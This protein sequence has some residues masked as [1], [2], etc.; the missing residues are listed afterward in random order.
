MIL[1]T[2]LCCI[3]QV[4]YHIHVYFILAVILIW[5]WFNLAVWQM[6]LTFSTD[7]TT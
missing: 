7:F 4:P 1:M 5:Q 6:V 2:I 3:E